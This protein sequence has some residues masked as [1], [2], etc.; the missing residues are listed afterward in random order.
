MAGGVGSAQACDT[1]KKK[2][3]NSQVLLFCEFMA[4][5]QSLG[6]IN[7][8]VSFQ[9]RIDPVEDPDQT[10]AK[11]T[12]RKPRNESTPRSNCSVR[13][14]LLCDVL[15]IGAEGW[16]GLERK[17][18]PLV[19][20]SDKTRMLA[21]WSTLCGIEG[22]SSVCN[23]VC[24]NNLSVKTDQSWRGGGGVPQTDH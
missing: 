8:G 6:F 16:G 17:T 22:S 3:R 19:F 18:A 21:F 24:L 20:N 9:T 11:R 1:G 14:M 4:S 10:R 7:F 2:W 23:N 5:F 13:T 12:V 15:Q